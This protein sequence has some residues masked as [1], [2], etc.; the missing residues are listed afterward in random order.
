MSFEENGGLVGQVFNIQ[1]YSTHDG[2]GI[3]TTVFLKG[4]PLRCFWC[5]NPESQIKQPVL[6]F[7]KDSCTLCGRCIVACPLQVNRIVDGELVVDRARCTACGACVSHCLTKARSIQGKDM[8]VEQVMVEV[9]KDFRLYINSGG[10]MTISGGDCEMQPAFTVALLEAAHRDGIHTAVEITGAFP[11]E[12]VKKIVDHTDFVLYDL[13]CMDE[14]RHKEGTGISNTH[15]LSNAKNIV[16][17]NKRIHFRMPLIPGFNDSREDVE[18]VAR[19]VRDGLGL[20]PADQLELLAYNNLGEDK[21][22]R[23]DYEGARPHYQRQSEAYIEELNA[24]RTSI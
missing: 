5:Q 21:Y 13:K 19:F 12:T 15:I 6:M 23:I 1:R 10:G 2:P 7:R 4:C 22:T 20:S 9:V 8:T 14:T 24:L 11:W 17:E 3:R 18:A 16:K